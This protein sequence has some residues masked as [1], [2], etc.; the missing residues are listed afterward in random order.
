MLVQW[1]E[2][3]CA[4]RWCMYLLLLLV[5]FLPMWKVLQILKRTNGPSNAFLSA[6]GS[7]PFSGFFPSLP[8]P[9]LHL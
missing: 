5:F 3:A 4:M 8:G 7:G 1:D 6:F 9:D 2:G